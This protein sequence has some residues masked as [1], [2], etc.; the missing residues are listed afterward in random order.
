M[1][2]LTLLEQGLLLSNLTA[3]QPAP[4]RTS[5]EKMAYM[6]ITALAALSYALMLGGLGVYLY[7]TIALPLA[8]TVMGLVLLATALLIGAA[9]QIVKSIKQRRFKSMINS[10]LSDAEQF[11][12]RLGSDAEDVFKNNAGSIA[13][14]TALA[15]FLA[16]RKII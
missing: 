3:G 2:I 6:A 10:A 13:L 16:A 7:Q 14:I 8:L 4:S 5:P 12:G 11:A 1:N 15:G 9:I